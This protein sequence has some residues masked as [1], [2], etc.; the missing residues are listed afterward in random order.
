MGGPL[1]SGYLDPEP[2]QS[3][4]KMATAHLIS[5]PVKAREEVISWGHMDVA[6]QSRSPC[7]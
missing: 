7:E 5:R 6:W 3:V 2:A 1:E 4:Y